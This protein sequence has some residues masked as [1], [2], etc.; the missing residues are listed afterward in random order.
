HNHAYA[1][2]EELR[3]ATIAFVNYYNHKQ[4]KTK[5]AGMTPV[6][7]RKHSSQFVA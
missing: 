7:F 4:I 3:T 1:N 2:F 6:E 5:L